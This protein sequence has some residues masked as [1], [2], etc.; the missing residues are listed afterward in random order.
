VLADEGRPLSTASLETY[1]DLGRTRLE[2]M[3]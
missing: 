2:Q 1:V 3:L